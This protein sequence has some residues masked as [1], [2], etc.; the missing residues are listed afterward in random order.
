[1]LKA[2]SR[3]SFPQPPSATAIIYYKPLGIP[4]RAWQEQSEDSFF[5]NVFA[6]GDA[7]PDEKLPVMVHFLS[8][9]CANVSEHLLHRFGSTEGL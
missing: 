6:P 9:S 2:T 3:T 4:M 8:P 5:V 1:M 7:K